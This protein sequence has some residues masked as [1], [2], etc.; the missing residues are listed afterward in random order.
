MDESETNS[1]V[2]SAGEEIRPAHDSSVELPGTVVETHEEPNETSPRHGASPSG[3]R[4]IK[5]R[6]EAVS[7]VLS[8]GATAHVFLE[9][10]A[11]TDPLRQAVQMFEMYSSKPDEM[12]HEEFTM[13]MKAEW[14]A[15]DF[16][17]Q[18]LWT[19]PGFTER[20]HDLSQKHV[21]RPDTFATKMVQL[22]LIRSRATQIPKPISPTIHMKAHRCCKCWRHSQRRLGLLQPA[23]WH[24]LDVKGD[25]AGTW[26]DPKLRGNLIRILLKPK[27]I[28][29]TLSLWDAWLVVLLIL[30]TVCIPLRIGFDIPT[31]LWDA[32]LVS[33]IIVDVSFI[34]DI[35]LSF[36]HGYE[37]DG[38]WITDTDLIARNYSGK[39]LL[40]DVVSCLPVTYMHLWF[41]ADL[42]SLKLTRLFRLL[43]LTK[44]VK[45][46]KMANV[47]NTDVDGLRDVGSTEVVFAGFR[48][49][50]FAHWTACIWQ[51]IGIDAE[52]CNRDVNPAIDPGSFCNGT[53][54]YG[55]GPAWDALSSGSLEDQYATSLYFATTT[56]STVGYGDILPV[57][58]A[59]R[60]FTS[61]AQVLGVFTFGYTMGILSA[62]I[63]DSTCPGRSGAFKWP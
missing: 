3:A 29:G 63:M 52:T 7:K 57:T 18:N 46:F 30:V 44:L 1:L 22:G 59:E 15:E 31:R 42:T 48:T 49:V 37:E 5:Q 20:R 4:Q 27:R 39:G 54:I 21:L 55:Y 23:Q 24:D 50:L 6:A 19:M 56:L 33:D 36:L 26:D 17:I 62:Y 2:E 60:V 38:K 9:K 43:R 11:A 32:W 13:M 41:S 25:P 8:R 14:D 28:F 51:F 53:W 10:L 34:A 58:T 61:I 35:F 40:V 47:M 12:L 45:L 16:A